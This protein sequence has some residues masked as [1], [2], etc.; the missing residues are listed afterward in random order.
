MG[1]DSFN[2][3]L[4]KKL[5]SKH[6]VEVA[7]PKPIYQ[8]Y[9]F[10]ADVLMTSLRII[11]QRF[12]DSRLYDENFRGIVSERALKYKPK[13]SNKISNNKCDF[14]RIFYYRKLREI[15]PNAEIIG[16]VAPISAWK[17]FNES[18]ARGVL[19]CELKGIY[20]SSKR[21]D[22]TYDFS[23]PSEITTRT[24]NT[25]D[26]SHYYPD[27]YD[28]IARILEGERSSFGVRIHQYNL[29][30]YQQFHRTK[31]KEFLQ[32]K[33]EGKRWRKTTL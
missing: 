13:F 15:F 9:L 2:F 21:F 32:K 33:G 25:Y 8:S 20:E 19:N 29:E 24:D 16:F 3:H 30:E 7:E 17:L 11:T 4:D 12:T 18:Y 1:I 22:A 27:V 23:H 5:E 10:S 6:K 28:K 26:G 14:S 31:L